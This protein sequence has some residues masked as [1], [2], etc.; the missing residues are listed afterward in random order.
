[1]IAKKSKS[2]LKNG[3]DESRVTNEIR[4][5]LNKIS[6]ENF[7]YS[8]EQILKIDYDEDLLDKFKVIFS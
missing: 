5:L 4:E 2:K 3:E 6:E 1:M 7:E 8:S